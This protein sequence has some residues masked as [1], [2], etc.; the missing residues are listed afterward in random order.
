MKRLSHVSRILALALLVGVAASPAAA[1]ILID[2]FTVGV[3][4]SPPSSATVFQRV[5]APVPGGFT[6]FSATKN[7]VS[8]SLVIT[9]TLGVYDYASS[10]VPNGG[11]ATIRGETS[12]D[13]TNS[14]CQL[15]LVF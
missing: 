6:E 14:C 1:D 2:D 3:T 9:T 11:N 7:A 5:A 10:S 13:Q 8:G 4:L 12:W 15:F